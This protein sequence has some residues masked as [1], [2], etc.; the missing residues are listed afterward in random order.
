[1]ISLIMD[2]A[3]KKLYVALVKDDM[4][5][6]EKYQ[7]GKNDH[8]KYIVKMVEDALKENNLGVDSLDRIVVGVGPGSYTGVRMAL[9]VGKIFAAFKNIPMYQIS[10]LFLMGSSLHEVADVLI[11]A[12]RGNVFGA[13]FDF[14]N[15]T[16]LRPEGHYEANCFS[17]DTCVT[18]D[19]FVVDPFRCIKMATLVDNPAIAV[20]NYLRDTEAERN[21]K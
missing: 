11:D 7:E 14:A 4:V 13:T 5:L 18:D 9:T 2:S 19:N 3:T 21:L 1:M 8:S 20:P 15:D 10:T 17:L 16:I 12:R 6:Y